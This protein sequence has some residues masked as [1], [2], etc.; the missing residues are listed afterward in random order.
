MDAAD[1]A[2]FIEQREIDADIVFLDDKTPTVEAAAD[3][4]GVTPAQIVKSVLFV[5]KENGDQ[6]R[7]VLV[8]A[9]GLSRIAYK[10]LAD[11]LGVSRRALRMARPAQVKTFTGYTVGTVPPFGHKEALPT[12]LEEGVTAQTEIYAGGGAINA[13]MRLTVAELQSVIGADVIALAE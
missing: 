4:V 7:P 2:R 11:Y 3:A 12:L 6:Y 9:N 10:K 8:V 5:V 1:L 13:L